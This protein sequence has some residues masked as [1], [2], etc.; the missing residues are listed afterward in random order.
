MIVWKNGGF[1]TSDEVKVDITTHALHYGTSVFE[2]IRAYN[3]PKG[4]AVLALKE[5]VQRFIYSMSVLGMRTKYS[6]DELS[7]AILLTVKKSGLDS[8][9]IRP[10][11]YFGTGGVSVLPKEDHQVDTIIYCVPLGKYLGADAVD[12]KI[13]K[14]IRIHPDSTV[15][16][17]KIGGHYINSLLASAECR[18]THYHESILL[19]SSGNIAEAA[20]MNIFMVKNNVIKTTPLGTILNGITRRVVIR[21]LKGLGYVVK[22]E[23]FKP[24]ELKSADEVFLCGTAAEIT[25]V[26]S[27]D[28]IKIINSSSSN[29]SEEVKEC[30]DRVKKAE[31]YPE[32]L[33]FV[34]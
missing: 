8:C 25:S 3:T 15:C 17:A 2:G 14:Y 28:D 34:N 29:I 6:V 18:G 19:D 22:E 12:V 4:V 27:V 21:I 10:L 31:L 5:H 11:A 16:D 32:L 20:A 33:T 24:E 13:S 30:F 1:Y 9:Y 26:A 7:E 23:Y